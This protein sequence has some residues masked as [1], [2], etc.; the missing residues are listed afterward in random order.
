MPFEVRIANVRNSVFAS[1]RLCNVKYLN[2]L[3]NFTVDD[4]VV[5]TFGF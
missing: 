5:Y 3:C 2:K 4:I 1:L